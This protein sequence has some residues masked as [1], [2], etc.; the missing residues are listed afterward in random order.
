VMYTHPKEWAD[1]H[2]MLHVLFNDTIAPELLGCQGVQVTFQISCLLMVHS[3]TL[4]G[5]EFKLYDIQWQKRKWIMSQQTKG[6]KHPRPTG[7]CL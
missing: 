4:S 7:I 6:R 1:V 2:Q 5:A 3:T